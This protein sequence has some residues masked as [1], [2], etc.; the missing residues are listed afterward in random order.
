[1][2]KGKALV[3]LRAATEKECLQGF[4]YYFLPFAGGKMIFET[5]DGGRWTVIKEL[6]QIRKWIP[7][8]AVI[9]VS[10]NTAYCNCYCCQVPTA[11]RVRI[12][13]KTSRFDHEQNL[14]PV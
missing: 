8:C 13:H 11:C 5:V 4:V 2:G 12:K 6:G 9:C 7:F 1:M 3:T 14:T 10:I